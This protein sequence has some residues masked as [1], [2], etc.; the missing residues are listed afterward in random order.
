MLHGF[1]V[2]QGILER[3]K[4]KASAKK[5]PQ[6][7]RIAKDWAADFGDVN[8]FVSSFCERG[9]TLE[10]WR[11][12]TPK[13]GCSV[14]FSPKKLREAAHRR[15]LW[16]FPCLYTSATKSDRIRRIF[17]WNTARTKASKAKALEHLSDRVCSDLLVE[18]PRFKNYA[19]RSEREWRLF[20][21][22]NAIDAD[23]DL[24]FSIK[25]AGLVPH[26]ILQFSVDC[27]EKII[28]SPYTTEETQ[29]GVKWF[30]THHG[31]GHV[32]VLRSRVPLR[33]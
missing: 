17:E 19:F 3:L 16:M 10:Q 1:E 11:G 21:F 6:L 15:N 29:F 25:P 5:V 28:L 30:L 7:A 23:D 2:V 31:F 18:V 9:D 33:A 13:G 26:L 12:Y 14:G 4:S 20:T 22:D 8:I 32:E 24:E 27:I